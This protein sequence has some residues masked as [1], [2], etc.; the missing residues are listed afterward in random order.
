MIEEIADIDL[1]ET[2]NNVNIKCEITSWLFQSNY[3]N[4]SFDE[5]IEK[6]ALLYNEDI[7]TVKKI[8][9]QKIK[10]LENEN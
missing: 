6:I 9:I 8:C 5:V 1:L 7:E 3:Y 10:E 2:D 4:N